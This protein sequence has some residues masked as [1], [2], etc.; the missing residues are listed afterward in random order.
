MQITPLIRNTYTRSLLTVVVVLCFGGVASGQSITPTTLP[1]G[2]VGVSYTQ[3]LTANGFVPVV[4]C[5]WTTPGTSWPAGGLTFFAPGTTT[6]AQISGTPTATISF[7]VTATDDVSSASQSYT[8]TINPAM[9]GVAPAALPA[10]D[11][12]VTYNQNLSVTGGTAPFTWSVSAVALP[13]GI[14]LTPS[15]SSAT[16]NGSTTAGTYNFT[17]KVTDNAGG[18]VTTAYTLVIN[19]AM[20]I[21]PSTLPPGDVG[22]TYNQNLSV[23]GGTAPFASSISAGALPTRITLTPSGATA[24]LSGSTAAGTYNFA[25]KV[26]D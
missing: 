20:S 10:G 3:T 14:I 9:S 23:T 1:D 18:V 15:G 12:G 13:A 4:C 2:D 16:L 21:S 26:T 19:P 25:V 8:I 5:T 22:V 17:V 11:A 24:T 6:T 7:T